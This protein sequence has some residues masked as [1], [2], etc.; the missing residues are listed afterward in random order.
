MAIGARTKDASVVIKPPVPTEV[1]ARMVCAF[2]VMMANVVVRTDV[3]K[4]NASAA[5]KM[6][7]NGQILGVKTVR[8]AIAAM[9]SA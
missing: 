8:I 5:Y 2:A 1:R 9:E 3:L 4:A 7:M 6:R